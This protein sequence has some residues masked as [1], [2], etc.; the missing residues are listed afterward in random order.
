MCISSIMCFFVED[1]RV[2]N[3]FYCRD[4]LKER[5]QLNVMSSAWLQLRFW[6]HPASVE[7]K[8]YEKNS[9]IPNQEGSDLSNIEQSP[10]NLFFSRI[11]LKFDDIRKIF[12]GLV[13]FDNSQHL[14]FDFTSL[15]TMLKNMSCT[16]FFLEFLLP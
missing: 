3:S 14:S 6:F 10:P 12:D 16:E 4:V 9:R 2:I 8:N 1:H 5:I 11:F 13:H 15:L 7:P